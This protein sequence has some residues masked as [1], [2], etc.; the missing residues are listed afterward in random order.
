MNQLLYEGRTLVGIVSSIIR[1][2]ALHVLYSRLDW[3]R[4]FRI[5]DAHKVANIV[6]L[7]VLGKGEALPDKWKERFFERYQEALLFGENCDESVR[8]ALTWLDM[9]EI[10][11]IVLTSSSVRDFYSI[12]ETAENSPIQILLDES[13]YYLAKGYLI[14]L[15]Y[16]T[17]QMYK[18]CGER[19]RRISG[20]S[21][22]LYHNLPFRTAPYRRGMS[23]IAETAVIKEPY[24]NIRM[25]PI[26][27]EFLFRIAKVTYNYVTDELTLRE[28][29]DLLLCHM[30]WRD[31]ISKESLWKGLE[32]FQIKE[33]AEKL[34]R[35]A[36]MWFGDKKENYI[37]YFSEGPEDVTV[38]DIL[39]DRLLT[40]GIIN[41]ES[42]T[43]A[44]RLEKLI[45]KEIKKEKR[46]EDGG[47]FQERMAE[48]WVNAKRKLKWVFPDYHYMSSIYPAVKRVPVL[49]PI[50]WMMR[51]MRLLM[52]ILSSK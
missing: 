13:Q 36:Y 18:G 6:Y 21:I 9:R 3:E 46:K 45:E 37:Q 30:T 43:E 39:E 25:L 31:E 8:E 2:D 35:I 52:R 12:P 26:E 4:M 1:Q 23:R 14:D 5:A 44:L 49:L 34:L 38:Y 48:Y 33:L 41:N 17:D 47:V 24:K 16:E 28:V 15:G 27:S 29:L 32:D 51:G 40:K 19:L 42:D 22:I 20:V 11:C 50:F 7:G 10:S